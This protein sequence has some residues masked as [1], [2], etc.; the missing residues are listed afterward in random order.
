MPSLLAV[1]ST[2]LLTITTL[3]LASPVANKDVS[4]SIEARDEWQV[5]SSNLLCLYMTNEPNWAGDGINLC[6]VGGTC[7]TSSPN[8]LQQYMR[9][10]WS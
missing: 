5:G 7:G 3:T 10:H 9:S 6:E 8:H 2:L 4:L 1:T